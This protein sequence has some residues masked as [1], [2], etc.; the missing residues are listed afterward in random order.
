[1]EVSGLI[2]ALSCSVGTGDV[3]DRSSLHGLALCS[4]HC[5]LVSV[6]IHTLTQATVTLWAGCVRVGGG[7]LVY[8]VC[9]VGWMHGCDVSG[10]GVGCGCG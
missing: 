7:A 4:I 1:M 3:H 8:G 9:V 6:A 10:W 2:L 5:I